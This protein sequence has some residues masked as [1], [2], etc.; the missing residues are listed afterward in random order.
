MNTQN[1]IKEACLRVSARGLC[2]ALEIDRTTLWRWANGVSKP[3]PEQELAITY[4]ASDFTTPL[5]RQK[6]AAIEAVTVV[7]GDVVYRDSRGQIWVGRG[8]KLQ[9]PLLLRSDK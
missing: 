5:P 6:P 7:R 3:T 8:H 9:S 2:D 4:C 1:M